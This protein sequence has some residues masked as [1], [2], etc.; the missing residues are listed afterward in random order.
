MSPVAIIRGVGQKRLVDWVLVPLARQYTFV[1]RPSQNV[2]QMVDSEIF[3]H[4]T[5]PLKR[6]HLSLMKFRTHCETSC[7]ASVTWLTAD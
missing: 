6:L 3:F 7:K 2:D 5:I 4:V 1:L